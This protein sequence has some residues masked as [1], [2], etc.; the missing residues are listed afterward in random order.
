MKSKRRGCYNW[1]GNRGAQSFLGRTREK[2]KLLRTAHS[3]CGS[4]FNFPTGNAQ[5]N[6]LCPQL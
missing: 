6:N 1:M 2:Q 5:R 3:F 4:A